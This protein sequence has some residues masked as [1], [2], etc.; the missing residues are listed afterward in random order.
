MITAQLHLGP[1]V[2][3]RLPNGRWRPLPQFTDYAGIELYEGAGGTWVVVRGNR[4]LTE[5]ATGPAEAWV[6]AFPEPLKGGPRAHCADHAGWR[7]DCDACAAAVNTNQS[8]LH[9]HDD[10]SV[11]VRS[12]PEAVAEWEEAMQREEEP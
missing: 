11:T 5:R 6:K 7:S 12:G 3:E 4:P 2:L 9:L 8:V 10:G 1:I